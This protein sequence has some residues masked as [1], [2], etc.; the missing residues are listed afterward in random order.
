MTIREALVKL[1]IDNGMF[2][3]QAR[4]VFERYSQGS[5]GESMQVRWDES[6]KAYPEQLLGVLWVGVKA[7]ALEWIDEKL[8]GAWFR[9]MFT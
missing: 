3:Y 6:T 7:E 8:P 1:L 9:L 4:D 5:L 2:D